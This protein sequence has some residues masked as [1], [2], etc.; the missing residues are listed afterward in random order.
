MRGMARKERGEYPHGYLTSE[1]RR[2]GVH[3]AAAKRKTGY[4][5]FAPCQRWNALKYPWGYIRV[6]PPWQMAKMGSN[7]APGIYETASSDALNPE[8]S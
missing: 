1:G 2:Q 4:A 7:A 5:H 6:V 3:P 8:V